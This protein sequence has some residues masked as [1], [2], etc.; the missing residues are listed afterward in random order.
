[1]RNFAV[2]MKRANRSL[3][4][5]KRSWSVSYTHLDV[6]KRQQYDPRRI[7]REALLDPVP[8]AAAE[9]TATDLGAPAG[10]APVVHDPIKSTPWDPDAT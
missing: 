1:M 2:P 7:V 5:P 10:P 4:T 6:Y 3:H 8:G 9:A